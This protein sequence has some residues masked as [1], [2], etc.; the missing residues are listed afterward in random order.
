MTRASIPS[1]EFQLVLVGPS[2]SFKA[3]RIQRVNINQ[4][5]PTTDVNE[6]G[7]SRLA[8]TSKDIPNV[9]VSFSAFDVGIKLFSVLTGTDP[10]AYPGAG[11]DI[12]ALGE[13]D[14]VFY[15]K[16]PTLAQYCKSG[17]A[18]RLQVRDFSYSYTLDGESTEDYTIIGSK[19]RWFS[20]EVVIDKFTTGTTT[21]TLTQTP[22]QL[23]NGEY[24]L[25]V[26]VN[27]VPATE[28]STAPATGEYR[29]VGT[30]L[31]TGDART[32]QVIAVYH[33]DSSSNVWTDVSDATMPAAVRGK[34]VKMR[35][36]GT[37]VGRLQSVTINGSLN[38]QA[39][40]EMG[41]REVVGYQKQVPTIDGSIT[42]LDLD[43][44]V[45]ALFQYGT[46]PS[47]HTEFSTGEGCTADD[48]SL[49]IEILDPCDT[50]EP[51]TVLKTIYIPE[52][53]VTGDAYSV[54]VNGNAG[55][56]YNFRSK[57]SQMIV[58][59]GSRP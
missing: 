23:D 11:V 19:K 3:S 59:S 8:G 21:F 18:K 44:T 7:N 46:S 35:L 28:V 40:R 43:N 37:E 24:L 51:Y 29:V 14:A 1:K 6:I 25:N 41:N 20:N 2:D 57:D 22:I 17:H 36:A 12:S 52:I 48:I 58:Y 53:E 9:T 16:D 39:V 54:N 5:N 42:I 26:I 45:P 13:V 55:V 10:L 31:T 49:Q 27:G 47:G 34:D 4:D 56:T 30:T 50:T 32:S 38:V 33:A 15:V